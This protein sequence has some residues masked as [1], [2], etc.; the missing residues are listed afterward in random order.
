MHAEAGAADGVEIDEVGGKNRARQLRRD[1]L[2]VD[3]MA[4]LVPDREEAAGQPRLAE[5]AG[6]ADIGAREG[7][8]EGMDGVVEPAAVEII[9]HASCDGLRKR[10]LLLDWVE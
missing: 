4:S 1:A 7:N 10:L 6:Y 9:A 2:L 5:A 8:L 3:A